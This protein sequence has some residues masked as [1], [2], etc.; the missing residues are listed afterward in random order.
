[1]GLRRIF[2]SEGF[3]GWVSPPRDAGKVS[4]AKRQRDWRER[5]SRL[6]CFVL[7]RTAFIEDLATDLKGRAVDLP[8]P[9]TLANDNTT[10]DAFLYPN[11]SLP[12]VGFMAVMAVVIKES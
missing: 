10:F 7:P 2:F 12:N 4:Q 3:T 6:C 8:P 11:R 9:P 5:T 1:M